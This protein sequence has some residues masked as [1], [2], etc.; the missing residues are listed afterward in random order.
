M[1]KE[2]GF[3]FCPALPYTALATNPFWSHI[4]DGVESEANKTNIKVTYRS[5]SE[6][7]QNSDTLLTMI[8]EMK[9]GGILLVGPAEPEVVAVLLQTNIPF[10]LVDNYVPHANAV[11]GNNYEG[12]RTATEYLINMGHRRI[13][14]LDGPL[15]SG[16]RRMN[17]VFTIERRAQGYRTALVDAGLPVINELCED[18]WLSLDGGYAACKRLC[19]RNIPFSAIFCANDEMAIGAM[20]ALRELGLR[21]PEDVSL[22]G[23]DDINIV[24]HLTPPLTTIRMDKDAMGAIALKR[25]LSLM[26]SPDPITTL[27]ILEVELV[28]RGSVCRYTPRQS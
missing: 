18:G 25:L 9:L 13:A 8:Y 11:L 10:L 17:K 22:V 3:L 14:L 26:S 27:T 21:V 16:P 28:E 12:A 23:F 2:I 5:L 6:N 7:Q 20:K 15:A 19:E 24:E 4:L 1:V